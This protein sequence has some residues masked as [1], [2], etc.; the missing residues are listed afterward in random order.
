MDYTAFR[1]RAEV[2]WI[3]LEIQTRT[4]TNFMT[5]RRA[6]G[7]KYVEPLDA[8]GGGAATVFR[9][10]IQDPENHHGVTTKL[11]ELAAR[12]PLAGI[13]VVTAV[14]IA[15]D[16]YSRGKATRD[17]LIELTARFRKFDTTPASANRRFGGR[18]KGDVEPANHH[19]TNMRR[20]AEGRVLNVGNKSDSR[21]QRFYF[22]CTDDGGDPIKDEKAHRARMENTLR[23]EGLPCQ[24]LKDWSE[25]DFTQL[26]G[27]YRF[28]MLE[29]DLSAMMQIVVEASPQ[30]GER[31]TTEQQKRMRARRLHS[32]L[33]PADTALNRRAYDAL[34]ELTRRWR[35]GGSGT[36]SPGSGEANG[37]LTGETCRNVGEVSVENPHECR[38]STSNSKD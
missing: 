16:A 1:F 23:S 31:R 15:L 33:T 32:R 10:R 21:S 38:E 8:A 20:L 28:R 29:S 13:P 34:R 18:W 26:S 12:F 35:A 27:M 19:A 22:K 37:A 24:A 7:L 6:M 5:V 9:F 4:P 11:D 30:L 36:E 14:E 3:E 17:D 25:F 2:D